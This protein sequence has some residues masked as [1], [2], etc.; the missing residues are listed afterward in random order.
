MLT[1]SL[2]MLRTVHDCFRRLEEEKAQSEQKIVSLS[3][4]LQNVLTISKNDTSNGDEMIE[5]DEEEDDDDDKNIDEKDEVDN[6]ASDNNN[7]NVDILSS[8]A[9]NNSAVKYF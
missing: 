5:E 2:E 4:I 8:I 7:N 9:A 6:T 1:S 3:Q